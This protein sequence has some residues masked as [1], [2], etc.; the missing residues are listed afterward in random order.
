MSGTYPRLRPLI[1]LAASVIVASYLWGCSRDSTPQAP[2]SAGGGAPVAGGSGPTGNRPP[3]IRSAVIFPPAVTIDTE[4]R[5]EVRGEDMDGDPITYRYQWLVNGAS[6]ADATAPQFKTDG[7]KNDDRITA[8]VTPND[9]KTDG[10]VFTTDPVTVGN[11]APYLVEIH[12]EPVPLRRGD[13]LK[14]K[15]VAADADG[16]PV[17]LS[18]KW[19]RNDKEIPGAKADTVETKDFK[20]KD[21]L[22]VLVTASD[23]KATREPQ[24]GLPVMIE[25]SPPSFTSSPPAEFKDGQYLY[26]VAVM[27]PDEDPITLEIKQGP[28]GMTLDAATKKIV[29]KLTPESV[30]KHHIVLVAKDNDNGVT[31]QDFDL[32]AQLP[33]QAAQSP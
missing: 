29:W 2:S 1:A 18:Y 5:V 8:Q 31:Q 30:G 15:V 22:A 10:V 16:D 6:A 28:P 25:N 21:V 9:G 24:A 23:G 26:A 14:V 3:V 19:L 33:P 13:P 12:L 4:L 20:K 32:D 7:L 27:D 17:T 11:T